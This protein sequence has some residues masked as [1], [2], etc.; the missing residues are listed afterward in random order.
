[1]RLFIRLLFYFSPNPF[2]GEVLTS[3]NE[4]KPQKKVVRLYRST[5]LMSANSPVFVP[6]DLDRLNIGIPPYSGRLVEGTLFS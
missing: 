4:E 2:L 3:Q 1:M 5:R 6:S